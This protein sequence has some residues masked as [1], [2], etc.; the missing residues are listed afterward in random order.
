MN[1]VQKKRYPIVVLV[2]VITLAVVA[3]WWG[4]AEIGSATRGGALSNALQPVI[5]QKDTDKS[6]VATVILTNYQ[7]TRI[8]AARWSGVYW[9]STFVAAALS[10]L[11]GLVLKLESILK[12]EAVKKDVAAIFAVTAA[13]LIT[14]S[15]SGDF[16]RKWQANRIASAELEHLG[17]DFLEKGGTN[18]RSYLAAVGKI[19]MT[20]HTS[21]LGS[22]EQEPSSVPLRIEGSAEHE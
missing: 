18:P 22:T 10:A 14:I 16:Q 1:S 2:I 4:F 17:Y 8:N 5:E 19:L 15:T 11:A 9:G 21:I 6:L 3:T 7:E 13:V 20:R 12:N